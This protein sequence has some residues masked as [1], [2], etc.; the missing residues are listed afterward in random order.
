MQ[1]WKEPFSTVNLRR[2]DSADEVGRVH[3]MSQSIQMNTQ[4][5]VNNTTYQELHPYTKD[6]WCWRPRSYWTLKQL[7]SEF[8]HQQS[9]TQSPHS[10]QW[11]MNA[12][13]H[14]R[15]PKGPLL[16]RTRLLLHLVHCQI[17][18][19]A[20]NLKQNPCVQYLIAYI[21]NIITLPFASSSRMWSG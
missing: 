4:T 16:E 1:P 14:H 19:A 21:L 2:T 9:S 7:T 17:Q 20:A 18:T 13:D 3:I 10:Y 6:H 11:S 12:T 8:L 5:L 15:A